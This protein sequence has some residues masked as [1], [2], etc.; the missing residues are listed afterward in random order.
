MIVSS[1]TQVYIAICSADMRKSINGL[2]SLVASNYSLNPLTGNFFVFS[3]KSRS[4]VKILY[5]H[6]N[7]YCLWQ[8]RLEKGRFIWPESRDD[9]LQVGQ[10]E[11]SWL[12]EGLDIHQARAHKRLEYSR[13]Y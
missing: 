1:T 10:R 8:K 13:V 6:I 3:N 5:W 11:L 2:S 12:L 9:V 4:I 7:G